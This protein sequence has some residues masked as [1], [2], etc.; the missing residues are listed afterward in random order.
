ML[1]Q[2]KA[3][4]RQ[5]GPGTAEAVAALR[6]HQSHHP[7][8]PVV[9]APAGNEEPR[10]WL[11]MCSQRKPQPFCVLS[12]PVCAQLWWLSTGHSWFLLL[13][14]LQRLAKE[15]SNGKP[16]Y[17]NAPSFHWA[18]RR[19]KE[20]VALWDNWVPQIWLKATASLGSAQSD[21]SRLHLPMTSAS[22]AW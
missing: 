4:S 12:P 17:P 19:H 20:S 2:E 1:S 6:L 3:R 13:L 15:S 21:S 14:E 8:L 9:P 16:K 22:P 11:H 7:P 18:T 5:P 10:P